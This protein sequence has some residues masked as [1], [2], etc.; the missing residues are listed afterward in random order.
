M[1]Q[2]S[3]S[4]LLTRLKLIFFLTSLLYSFPTL[5]A[6]SL[7]LAEANPRW[8]QIA[9]FEE[10]GRPT[11][12]LDSPSRPVQSSW[13]LT[14]DNDILVPGGRDQDYT[15]GINLIQSGD[16]ARIARIS[17]NKPLIAI[18]KWLGNTHGSVAV[19][20]TFNREL[21]LFGFT[22]EAIDVRVANAND[23]PYASLVYLAS[24]REQVNLVNNIAWK[25]TLTIGV[26]GLDIVGDL[27]DVVHEATRSQKPQGWENQISDGGELTGRYAIARQHYIDATPDN[28]EIKSTVQASVG[29]LTEASWSLSFRNGT[30]HSPWSS[31]NPELSSYGEKSSYS[32]DAKGVNEH[33]LWGGFAVKARA[34]NAFLQGQ[35]RDSTVSYD[36]DQLNS[37][38]VEAWIG[39]TFAFKHGYRV[40]YVLRGHTSEVKVGNG[41]RDLLWGGLIIARNL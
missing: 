20:Q 3:T 41:N 13:A 23:R 38:L 31:F 6:Q 29:Y 9:P 2:S 24:S 36:R 5:T 12:R 8:T 18:D 7:F 37:L 21:G 32:S 39:Y 16:N 14:F 19:Q 17:L 15:Y 30:I 22:P 34:Y 28:I 10:Q 4:Y 27:Q 33:Y 35:F 40:S 11:L 26:L 25:S 1:D